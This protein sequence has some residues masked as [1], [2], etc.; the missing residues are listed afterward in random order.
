MGLFIFDASLIMTRTEERQSMPS[1][2]EAPTTSHPLTLAGIM[3]YLL[4]TLWGKAPEAKLE[5]SY[6]IAE[7][8]QALLVGAGALVAGIAYALSTLRPQ[9]G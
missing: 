3:F 8:V 4:F 7:M 2:A 6:N 9:N 5:V 1:K